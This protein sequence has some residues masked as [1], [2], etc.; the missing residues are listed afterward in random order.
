[1]QTSHTKAIIREIESQIESIDI[2]INNAV[3]I[4]ELV[5]LMS[6]KR[7]MQELLNQQ[8]NERT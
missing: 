7:Q 1:M 2:K 8:R 6:K 4:S 5:E 3:L